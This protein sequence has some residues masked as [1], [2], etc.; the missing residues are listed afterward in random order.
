[1]NQFNVLNRNQDVHRHYLLEASAGTGKTF[2]IENIVVRLLLEENPK[3]GEPLTLE[4][5]LVVTFTRTAT[6]DLNMRIRSNLETVLTHLEQAEEG[7]SIAGAPDYLNALIERGDETISMCKRRLEHALFCFDQAQIFTIHTFCSRMLR[8]NL[9]ESD[10]GAGSFNE[11]QPIS[12][13]L[14]LGII[15]DYFRTGITSSE[16]SPEQIKIVLGNKPMEELEK[17]LIKILGKNVEI[18]DLPNYAKLFDASCAAMQKLRATGMKAENIIAD[19]NIQAPSYKKSKSKD[20]EIKIPKFSTLFEKLNFTKEDFDALIADG[21]CFVEALDPSLIRVRSKPISTSSLHYPELYRDLKCDLWPII[22]TARNPDAILARIARG[23]QLMLQKFLREE[24]KVGFDDILKSMWNALQNPAFVSRVRKQ[25]RAAIIDEFQDTDPVQWDIFRTLFPPQDNSWGHLYLV[26][27]PKQSIYAFRQADI[28]TYLDAANSMG[29]ENMASL[30]TNYRS[31]PQLIT[32]LNALFSPDDCPGMISLP[33]IGQN[34]SYTKIA[35]P[36]GKEEKIFADNK[37]C[38][39]FCIARYEGNKRSF[40]K[41]EVDDQFFFPFIAREIDNLRRNDGIGFS[42]FAI[43]VKDRYQ[44]ENAANY[45]R[46]RHIPAILQKTGNLSDSDALPALRDILQGILHPRNTSSVKIALGSKIIGWTH[47]QVVQM[48][49]CSLSEHVLAQFYRLRKTLIEDGFISFF[50]DFLQSTWH[51]SGQTVSERL[52][53]QKDGLKLYQDMY[54]LALIL[55][56]EEYQ[57]QMHPEALLTLLDQFQLQ[58]GDEDK[59]LVRMQDPCQEAVQILTMHSSK[60]LEFDIVF[61]LGLASRSKAPDSLIPLH[62]PSPKLQVITDEAAKEYID[63]CHEID[64]EKM[65]QLYVTMTRA[66]YRVYAPVVVLPEKFAAKP[67]TASPMELFLARL[68]QPNA[69]YEDLYQR[70][71][72]YTGKPL[73]DFVETKKNPITFSWLEGIENEIVTNESCENVNLIQPIKFP[74]PGAPKFIAS[75]STLAHSLGIERDGA[76]APH[77]F[78]AETKSISQL[79][80]GNETGN[81][82]HSILEKVPLHAA[83]SMDISSDLHEWIVPFIRDTPFM[84]WKQVIVQMIHRAMTTPLQSRDTSFCLCDINPR[85]CYRETEFLFANRRPLNVGNNPDFLKG[86]IDLFFM[87]DDKYYLLDWKSNWLGNNPDDYTK[88]KIESAMHAEDYFLQAN[89]YCEALRKYLA[90]VDRRD[91]DKIFGGVFYIFL[92]G[93]DPNFPANGVYHFIPDN[94]CR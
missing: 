24:E 6:R 31:Q 85:L 37:G 87:H 88:D 49:S 56:E 59:R 2:S 22:E 28:Y 84:P 23:C 61:A 77:D 55:A 26:G 48:Q 47:K 46:S 45:L 90:L 36:V 12:E 43:L 93:L 64:S 57:K 19:F 21:L 9:F 16:F 52:L 76:L 63:Y 35:A 69:T 4:Q 44:A 74:I 81:M 8:D 89:V 67:G 15:R 13:T 75:F 82:L 68:G 25:Y 60:G 27:D 10:A 42:Q 11:V 79:P 33:R 38:V 41:N 83:K 40:P 14:I 30:A 20:P 58:N 51:D 91:F 29:P 73:C 65:R 72:S 1:M 7:L 5:I 34:L 54:Q 78:S 32:A 94:S 92:R 17:S 53:S 70:I 80:S 71:N 3:T 62:H 50:H 66:K 39:H 86:V 18:A